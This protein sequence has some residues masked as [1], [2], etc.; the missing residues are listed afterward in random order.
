MSDLI[1]RKAVI[2]ALNKMCDVVCQYS[3]KQRDVMCGACS[4]G[5]AFDV[6]EA[7]PSE[8]PEIIRCKECKHRY[9]DGENVV[10]NVC[11]LNHNKVQSDDWYCADAERRTDG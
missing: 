11:E 8:Q 5:N 1:D 2:D 9:T 6:I 4:L 7:L 3:K 10:F